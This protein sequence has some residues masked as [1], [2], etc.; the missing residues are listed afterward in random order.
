MYSCFVLVDGIDFRILEPI[1]FSVLM[2][3]FKF[4]GA[5]V[6]YNV[7]VLVIAGILW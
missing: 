3:S 2:H 7:V 5:A 6:R 1:P 4:N